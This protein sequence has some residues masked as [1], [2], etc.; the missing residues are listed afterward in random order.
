MKMDSVQIC[1][2]RAGPGQQQQQQQQQKQQQQQQQQHPNSRDISL[3]S[4]SDRREILL[5]LDSVQ[6]CGFWAGPGNYEKRKRAFFLLKKDHFL[7][8]FFWLVGSKN[9]TRCIFCGARFAR[10]LVIFLFFSRHSDP[11]R[12]FT[13]WGPWLVS[14]NLN[15]DSFLSESHW[16]ETGTGHGFP[17]LCIFSDFQNLRAKGSR[18]RRPLNSSHHNPA[19]LRFPFLLLAKKCCKSSLT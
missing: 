15:S 8:R 16:N 11:P 12:F 6:I 5:N 18:L 7:L 9:L 10:L 17:A 14:A 2:F 13:K 1:G 19:S 3:L 4:E